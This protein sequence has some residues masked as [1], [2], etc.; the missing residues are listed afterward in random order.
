MRNKVEEN[1]KVGT[2]CLDEGDLNVAAS[3]IYFATFQAVLIFFRSKPS[4]KEPSAGVHSAVLR[5]LRDMGGRNIPVR[6]NLR[7]LKELRETA[8]YAPETPEKEEILAL[9]EIA[10]KIKDDYLGKA[11]P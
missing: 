5:E 4:F 8:D 1:W 2:S 6:N 7:D 3:R 11:Q 10:E 9:L